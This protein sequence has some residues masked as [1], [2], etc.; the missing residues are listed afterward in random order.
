VFSQ[1][2]FT[3]NYEPLWVISGSIVGSGTLLQAS[4]FQLSISDKVIEFFDLP[5]LS[6]LNMTVGSTASEMITRILPGK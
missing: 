3:I 5:N 2:F 1:F 6:I 4:R